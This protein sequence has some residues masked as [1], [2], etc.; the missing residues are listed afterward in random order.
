MPA[1]IPVA[2]AALV[3]L[4]TGWSLRAAPISDPRGWPGW[5]LGLA[6]ALMMLGIA[7][8]SVAKRRRGARLAP[9]WYRAHLLLGLG[10]PIAVITH[11][12]FGW[13][14]VNAGFTLVLTLL[15]LASGLV[16]R[17]VLPR[18]R[19]A[20]GVAARIAAAW[21]YAHAPLYALLVPAVLLH[22]YMAHAY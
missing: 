18:A 2:A 14:S 10:G 3:L 21:H 19:R 4:A 11:A 7:G 6:G 5:W 12:R 17:Y 9:V 20:G 13:Q 22:V 1:D 16:A 15:I 8:F